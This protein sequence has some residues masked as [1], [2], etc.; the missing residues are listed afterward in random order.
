M[1]L[2][3]HTPPKNYKISSAFS[4]NFKSA[5]TL[6]I[7]W[8]PVFGSG[9]QVVK[10]SDGGKIRFDGACGFAR[11][12]E[13]QN[14]ADDVFL[15]DVCQLLE[16][17]RISKERT[18]PLE[19]LIVPLPGAVAALPVVPRQLVELGNEGIVY[20]DVFHDVHI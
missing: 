14:I 18:K 11:Q 1:I 19:S 10:E 13:I 9:Y 20:T 2:L 5:L 8:Q 12:L 7:A 15:T 6:I 17:E 3:P 4:Y 16:M